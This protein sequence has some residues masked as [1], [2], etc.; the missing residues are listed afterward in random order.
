ML[1]QVMHVVFTDLDG[2]LLDYDT[3]SFEAAQPALTRLREKG[4]P[5]VFTTSKTR[6][7]TESLRARM[8]NTDPFITGNGGAVFIPV[9][10]F[11]FVPPHSERLGDYHVIEYGAPYEVLIATLSAA[12]RRSGCRVRGF[13]DLSV[14][15]LAETCGLSLDEAALAKVR[16]YDEPF[17][18]LDGPDRAAR[19]L[20]EIER[21]GKR[22]VRG[23]RFYHILG[24]SDKGAAVAAL[25][26]LYTRAHGPV[27]AIGLGDGMNDVDFLK[28]VDVPILIQSRSTKKMQAAVSNGRVTAAWGPRGWNAAILEMFPE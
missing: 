2:T 18:I 27:I 17:E 22:W 13:A 4:I 12:S 5:V 16:E 24:N 21:L 7:E 3:Y 6:A 11:P 1:E 8:G 19:L 20:A 14:A 15:E 23:G 26:A 9:S 25:I 28:I 10:Y